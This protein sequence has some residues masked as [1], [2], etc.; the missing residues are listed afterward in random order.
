MTKIYII[1]AVEDM[2]SEVVA[3]KILEQTARGY[4]ITT[5]MC[6]GGYGYLRT[7]IN[8]FNRA[9][10]GC[11]FFVLTDQDDLNSCPP[12]KIA[13]WL[14]QECNSNL[15]FRIAVMEVESWILAHREA[16]A[17][18][19]SVPINRIPD[20]TDTIPDPKQFLVNLARRSRF[21]R[22]RDAL[23]PVTGSSSQQGPDYTNRLS[24]FINTNWDVNVAREHSNSLE[25]AYSRLVNFVP[26]CQ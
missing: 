12:E 20:D 19:L 1:L 10:S 16:F 5:C 3:R 7:N 11:N 25:R 18:F 22:L 8:E 2:L 4:E 9:A 15:I 24:E 13:S 21:T 14:G 26:V 23:I 6:R 17:S